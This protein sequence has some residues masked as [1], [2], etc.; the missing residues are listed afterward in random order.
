MSTCQKQKSGNYTFGGVH[1]ESL[2]GIAEYANM[3][4]T[5]SNNIKENFQV[6]LPQEISICTIFE[7]SLKY[8]AINPAEVT[9]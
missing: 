4:L 8:V 3:R 1:K 7:F 9:K 5:N 2:D 6:V